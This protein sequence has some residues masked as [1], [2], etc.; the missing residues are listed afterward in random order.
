MRV[1]GVVTKGSVTGPAILRVH[2][3]AEGTVLRTV[4]ME[5]CGNTDLDEASLHAMR[6]MR[7]S[8]YTVDGVPV[9]VTLA[10]PMHIPKRLGRSH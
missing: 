5:S 6:V 7:F 2:I 1:P 8:P 3:S 10:V 9:D 4:L